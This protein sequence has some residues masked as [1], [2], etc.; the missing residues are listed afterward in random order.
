[1]SIAIDQLRDWLEAQT[2]DTAGHPNGVG[3]QAH[4]PGPSHTDA[5]RDRSLSVDPGEKGIVLKCFTGCTAEEVCQALGIDMRDLF[6]DD[7]GASRATG[8]AGGRGAS[9]PKP[10][11]Q[12]QQAQQPDAPPTEPTEPE[13]EQPAEPTAAHLRSM[14]R[15]SCC[16]SAS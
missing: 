3:F 12:V 13:Q 2:G 7:G 10:Q 9:S 1:M 5:D 15:R 11:Q 8:A 6:Y 16:L 14:R 4:C